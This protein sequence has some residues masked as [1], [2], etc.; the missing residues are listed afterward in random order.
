MPRPLK[1]INNATGLTLIEVL[2]SLALLSLM[3]VSILAAF[4]PAASW[5]NKAR[6]ETTAS[7]YATSI[8]ESLRSDRSKIDNSNEGKTAHYVFPDYG[9]PWA[10]MSDEITRLERQNSPY[11]NLYDI[12]VTVSWL[13]GSKTRSIKISTIVKKE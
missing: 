3:T 7:N 2:A 9:Y 4:T 12:T 13:E 5:I 10:G 8:L 6:R 11:N 1:W